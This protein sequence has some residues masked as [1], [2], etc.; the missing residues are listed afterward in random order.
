MT[1]DYTAQPETRGSVLKVLGLVW[2]PTMDDFVFD[3]RELLDILKEKRNT[4]RSSLQSSDRIFDLLGFLTPFAIR[5]K[6]LFQEMWERGVK[7]DEELP[8]DLTKKWQ[9]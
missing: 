3:L 4:K 5:I 1:V 7:W 6:C 9:Q 2:R 8:P